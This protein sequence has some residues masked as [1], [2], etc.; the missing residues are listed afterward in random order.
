MNALSLAAYNGYEECVRVLVAAKANITNTT[1]GNTALHAAIYLGRASIC[2][3]LVDEGASITAV[4]RFGQTPIQT[5][6][7]FAKAE[8][9]AILEAAAA[10]T[11]RK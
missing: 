7:K 1:N 6:K 4:D 3:L 2:R 11:T 10:A 8:C 9:V 5:A